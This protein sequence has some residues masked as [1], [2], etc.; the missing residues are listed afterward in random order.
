MFDVPLGCL[1]FA[2][3]MNERVND[4]QLK[5]EYFIAWQI[6]DN[7][8]SSIRRK[9]PGLDDSDRCFYESMKIVDL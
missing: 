2:D 6:I 3:S 9:E 1:T 4:C 5:L 8:L 7:W